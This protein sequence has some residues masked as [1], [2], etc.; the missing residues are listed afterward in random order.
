MTFIII[1]NC[2]W[3]C[4]RLLNIKPLVSLVESLP[5]YER[6][7]NKSNRKEDL[8]PVKWTRWWFLHFSSSYLRSTD[9]WRV[10][11]TNK[12]FLMPRGS[13]C[14]H[15]R[16]NSLKSWA[17]LHSQMLTRLKFQRFHRFTNVWSKQKTAS[18]SIPQ[19]WTRTTFLQKQINYFC[20]P[21][22]VRFLR[23]KLSIL[24]G[25]CFSWWL[26]ALGLADRYFL[27]FCMR[28]LN[29]SSQHSWL[30]DTIVGIHVAAI[31]IWCNWSC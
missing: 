16:K 17:F 27:E 14:K 10:D 31:C 11:F 3:S 8:S 7:P 29:S 9:R 25:L 24:Y 6:N 18:V 12:I 4:L 13:Q 28:V 26:C 19:N 20:S 5:A 30:L 23:D 21:S 2:S 15:S 22:K 1:I